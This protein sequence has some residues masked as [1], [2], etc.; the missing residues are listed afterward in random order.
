MVRIVSVRTI[1][2]LGLLSW[3]CGGGGGGGSG[4]DDSSSGGGG[5]GEGPDADGEYD[6]DTGDPTGAS[7][8]CVTDDRFFAREVWGQTLES[9]CLGCHNAQGLASSTDFVLKGSAGV[10]GVEEANLAAFTEMAS[11]FEDDDDRPII[12]RKPLGELGHQGGPVL[13]QGDAHYQRLEEAVARMGAP[14]TK[15]DD[16]VDFLDGVEMESPYT[17]LRRFALLFAYRLP[18]P[19][20]IARVDADGE[21]ALAEIIDEMMQEEAF[22]DRMAEGFNDVFLTEGAAFNLAGLGTVNHP[23]LLWFIDLPQPE[24]GEMLVNTRSGVIRAGNQ[25]VKNIVLADEPFTNVL[26][27]NYTMVNPFSARSF[28]VFDSIDWEDP[29][30]PDEFHPAQLHFGASEAELPHAGI[31]NN[32][33]YLDRYQSTPTNVNRARARAFMLHFLGVDILKFAP[34]DSDPLATIAEYDNP[35]RDADD[36]AIC[37]LAVDPIA[38]IFHNYQ[39][40]GARY[41]GPVPEDTFPAGFDLTSDDVGV[42]VGERVWSGGLLPDS[43]RFDALRWLGEQAV[44]DPRFTATMVKHIFGLVRGRP[45]L[46]PPIGEP[47]PEREGA[48]RAYEAQQEAL[49]EFRAT[50]VDSNYSAKTLVAA[51]VLSPFFRARY[52]AESSAELDAMRFDLGSGQI[53]TPEQLHRKIVAIFGDSFQTYPAYEDALMDFGAYRILY[54]GIDS[55]AVTQRILEPNGIMAGIQQLVANN[56]SCR[57]VSREFD[58]PAGERLLLG[59]VELTTFGDGEEDLIRETLVHLHQRVVGERLDPSDPAITMSY[60][61]FRTVQSR[62]VEEQTKGTVSLTLGRACEAGSVTEDPDYV[63]RAWAAVLNYQMQSFEFLY[64]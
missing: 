35:V 39:T 62:G 5:S 14:T 48:F 12:L 7:T 43:R 9:K 1:L 32:Y 29:N 47:S 15:C 2:A 27:A 44:D 50:F 56:V 59:G 13:E 63:V 49:E 18:T 34:T 26:L 40:D 57:Q 3:G 28:G 41:N 25:L 46:E 51:I 31:L 30:D 53:L 23:S 11:R 6:S 38:G 21:Q 36:C 24:R 37:H 52:Q 60:E 8:E 58:R 22:G 10:S 42:P 64:Q 17:T 54:G 20:E 4:S 45:A 19:E 55:T 16:D 33:I 61:L